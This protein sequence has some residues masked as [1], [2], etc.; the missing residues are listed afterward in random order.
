[1]R[2][3]RFREVKQFL[4]GY[5][6]GNL[7]ELD[8]NP[9]SSTQEATRLITKAYCLVKMQLDCHVFQEAFPAA[10]AR[11]CISCVPTKHVLCLSSSWH[12]PCPLTRVCMFVVSLSFL[13]CELPEGRKD[14]LHSGTLNPE[15]SAQDSVGAR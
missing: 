4:Q 8:L 12:L 15:H 3:L 5:P 14:S 2:K 11:G 1:M 9:R 6:A 7:V 13:N 10:V